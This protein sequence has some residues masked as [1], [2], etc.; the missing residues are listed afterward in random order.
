MIRFVLSIVL[1]LNVLSAQHAWVMNALCRTV[2]RKHHSSPPHI[3]LSPAAH[4]HHGGHG[5][6]H[7]HDEPA[8]PT[9]ESQ[10]AP[11]HDADAVYLPD[12]DVAV[13]E[14]MKLDEACGSSEFAADATATTFRTVV[15]LSTSIG[16]MNE[17]TTCKGVSARPLYVLHMSLLI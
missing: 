3:H 6:R 1:V 17:L 16:G 9:P 11:E 12:S 7:H 5:H 4:T 8:L 13:F 15:H 14:R 10:T 2:D